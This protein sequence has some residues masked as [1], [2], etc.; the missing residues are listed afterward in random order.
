M[1]Q[2]T[3][4]T[5]TF[6][7][8]IAAAAVA[9]TLMTGIA[10]AEGPIEDFRPATGALSREQVKAEVMMNRHLLTSYGSEWMQQQH[11][12]T[13]PMSGYSRAQA[14]ADYIAAR[15]EVRAMNAEDS[16]SGYLAH[17]TARAPVPATATAA[18]MP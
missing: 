1:H 4:S 2:R 13:Q 14:T 16:G 8:T 6:I 12:M 11:A 3:T 15:E 5:L 18:A 10:H 9:A 7:G 17:R